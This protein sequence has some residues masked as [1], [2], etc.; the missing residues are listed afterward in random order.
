MDFRSPLQHPLLCAMTTLL[1]LIL[2][3]G[4]IKQSGV[5]SVNETGKQP[6]IIALRLDPAIPTDRDEVT[7]WLNVTA[8][9]P[10][11]EV[12]IYIDGTLQSSTKPGS[13]R[14]AQDYMLGRLQAGHRTLDVLVKGA[15]SLATA[16]RDIWVIKGADVKDGVESSLIPTETGQRE[17]ELA[18]ES[19]ET[20]QWKEGLWQTDTPFF[21]EVIGATEPSGVWICGPDAAHDTN[22]L[23]HIDL[24]R[25][26]KYLLDVTKATGM[27]EVYCIATNFT[28]EVCIG[29]DKGIAWFHENSFTW[30]LHPIGSPGVLGPVTMIGFDHKGD[31]WGSLWIGGYVETERRGTETLQGWVSLYDGKEWKT[32]TQ[33]LV[34][35]Y[36]Q[37]NWVPLPPPRDIG[38]DMDGE[39]VILTADGVMR[40]VGGEFRIVGHGSFKPPFDSPASKIYYDKRGEAWI[41]ARPLVSPWRDFLYYRDDPLRRV[42]FP[43]DQILH[44]V[45]EG[46][47]R[48]WVV[49][50]HCVYSCEREY[51]KEVWKNGYVDGGPHSFLFDLNGKLYFTSRLK[52]LRFDY[53]TYGDKYMWGYDVQEIG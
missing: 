34:Y 24:S 6:R 36:S 18:W 12:A 1:I 2:A 30:S 21:S 14:L 27:R 49:G 11:R 26:K 10:I 33:A 8:R 15:A 17:A 53:D 32:W 5:P 29:G 45:H 41:I 4:C 38:F 42:A 23:M 25:E 52:L 44:Q 31:N 40:L 48:I 3:A 35:P 22:S 46:L 13:K 43:T 19:L 47:G 28:G 20:T 16:H 50:T 37:E 9:V 7:L 51:G 39:P